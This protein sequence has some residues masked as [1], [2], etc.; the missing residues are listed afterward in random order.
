MSTHLTIALLDPRPAWELLLGQLGVDWD[1]PGDLSALS[2]ASH[3]AVICNRPLSG[4]SA[5][6]LEAYLRQ[7]GAVLD[8]GPLFEVLFNERPNRT[9]LRTVYPGQTHPLFKG[10]DLIDLFSRHWTLKNDAIE[11]GLVAFRTAGKGTAAFLGLD[12]DH[13]LLD[14]RRQRKAFY[15]PDVERFPNELVSR[16]SK[17]AVSRLVERLLQELFFRR[18]LPYVHW[19]HYP[20]GAPT[21]FG[22]R[23]DSD[24]GERDRIHAYL[25]LLDEQEIPATWFVHAEAHEDWIAD[26]ATFRGHEIA[27][28]GYRHH[29]YRDYDS[30]ASNIRRC[31]ALL[32]AHGIRARGFAAPYGLWNG[33]LARVMDDL[34]LTYSSEFSLA[35]DHWPF[36]PHFRHAALSTLQVP[37]HPVCI[38]SLANAGFTPA[39]MRAY[40][41]GRIRRSLANHDPLLLY[42][43]PTHD[44]LDVI[45]DVLSTVRDAGIP[46]RTLGA[47][48]DW[49]VT[50]GRTRWTGVV[51]DDTLA[52]QA[53]GAA[54]DLYLGIHR[55]G[56]AARVRPASE[57]DLAGLRWERSD[58]EALPA[59]IRRVRRFDPRRVHQSI[60]TSY[61]RHQNRRRDER[62][63]GGNP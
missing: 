17:G 57:I 55:S 9:Y 39:A 1:I 62:N 44:H 50:R 43:H 31:Q 63:G 21:L 59:D 3:A 42:D 13:L 56:V 54:A 7:G 15:H 26:F 32:G 14:T 29:T 41:T 25:S 33:R 34:G 6:A 22:L 60:L 40:F 11:R 2:P 30:N 18:R 16:V 19:W 12:L 28:H 47:Y 61:W 20:E 36:H 35:Y 46:C 51:R 58:P 8:T 45:A 48:A 37:V 24:Y 4:D 10:I 23:L 52:V 27:A 5:A 53:E 49:W 38:G